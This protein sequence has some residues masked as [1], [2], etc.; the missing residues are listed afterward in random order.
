MLNKYLVIL[1]I[2]AVLSCVHVTIA[3]AVT[4]PASALAVPFLAAAIGVLGQLAWRELRP[5][6][7]VLCWRTA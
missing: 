4:V 3:G 5:G 2:L 7:A 1:A 6:R